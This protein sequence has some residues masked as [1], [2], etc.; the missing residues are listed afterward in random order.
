MRKQRG[1]SLFEVVITL[2]VIGI[3]LSGLVKVIVVSISNMDYSRN[4]N[5][6]LNLAQSKIEDLRQERDSSQWSV[7]WNKYFEINAGRQSENNLGRNEIFTRRT[8]F[9]NISNPTENNNLMKIEVTVTWEDSRGEHRS[10][11]ESHL[12]EWK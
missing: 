8:L 12:A 6:A 9:T 5:L 11:I 3:I 4:Q 2:V 1:Q 7:F 10:F